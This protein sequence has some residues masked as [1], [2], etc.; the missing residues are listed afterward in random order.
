MMFCL[1]FSF[2]S[3]KGRVLVNLRHVYAGSYSLLCE[4]FLILTVQI[5]RRVVVLLSVVATFMVKV[6][7]ILIFVQYAQMIADQVSHEETPESLSIS[8][9]CVHI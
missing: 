9:R 6:A 7:C 1:S 2:C 3:Y 8:Y 5:C 4:V